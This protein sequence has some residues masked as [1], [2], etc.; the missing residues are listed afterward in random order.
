MSMLAQRQAIQMA[1]TLGLAHDGIVD[2]GNVMGT[3]GALA[4][5]AF[6]PQQGM[7]DLQDLRLAQKDLA[8]M[9]DTDLWKENLRA[10]FVAAW[11]DDRTGWVVERARAIKAEQRRRAALG[12]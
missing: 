6:L 5:R 11:G 7:S 8:T 3:L 4:E 12:K 10:E 9:T 2:A 1:E